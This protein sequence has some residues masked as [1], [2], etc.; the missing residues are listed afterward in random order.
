[1]RR[2]KRCIGR[3]GWSAQWRCPDPLRYG[4]P[5]AAQSTGLPTSGG[6]L[7]WPLFTDGF[8]DWGQ[9]GDPGQITLTNPGTA[10]APIPL[11]V[12][13][14]LPGGFEV[15]ADGGRL[16]YPTD[17]PA[18]QTIWIDT[19]DGSVLAE[20]TADRRLN[21]TRADWLL[22]PAGGSMTLQFTGLGAYSADARL[23]VPGFQAV[24][25]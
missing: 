23:T 5:Q 4:P 25:W 21:L 13:G 15:S 17:V 2:P 1:M 7:A 8:L 18:G 14:P 22:V 19:G 11:R 12:T 9:P 16:T 20:G 24:Y 10:D 3:F 6:G